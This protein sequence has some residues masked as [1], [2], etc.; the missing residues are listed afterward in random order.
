VLRE[1][2]YHIGRPGFRSRQ[3]TLVTTLL[4]AGIYGVADLAELY[5]QRWQ[6]ETSL[7]HLKTTMRM[8]VL[9]GKTVPGVLKELTVFAIVYNLVRIAMWHSAILQH[10][11][12]ERISFLDALR[13]LG[14]PSTG[15]PLIALLVNPA[16]P[17]RVEPRV[18]KR[19]S[20]QSSS[21]FPGSVPFSM[22]AEGNGLHYRSP[23]PAP[24]HTW[25]RPPLP[26]LGV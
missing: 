6:I 12:V 7:A 10:I 15:M 25:P 21:W 1:V 26:Q 18:K 17:Y 24:R 14:A 8:D 9:H 3:V 22:K 19:R 2:R 11:A 23:G 16:R 4:D 5:Q 13:W 20:K